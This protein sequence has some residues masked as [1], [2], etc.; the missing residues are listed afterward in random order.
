VAARAIVAASRGDQ[1]EIF[2]GG[3]TV[4][5]VEGTKFLPGLADRYLAA[6]AFDSQMTEKPM[7]PDR[8]DNLF[9]P[10]P[11]DYG[12]HGRFET[13]GKKIAKSAW[14]SPR[15]SRGLAAIAA[16]AAAVAIISRMRKG[17]R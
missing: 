14:V 2:V 4:L 11:G 5:A 12:A 13:N 3:P 7:D 9:V 1:R 16:G 17:W 15:P 8:P 10:V 6:T